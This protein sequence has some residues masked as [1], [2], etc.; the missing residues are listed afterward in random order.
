MILRSALFGVRRFD[1]FQRELGTP[2]TVLSERLKKLVEN[3]LMARQMYKADG[4][5][6]RPE[7]VLTPMGEALRPALISLTQWA[8]DWLATGETPPLGFSHAKTRKPVRAGFVDSDGH[9]V[10][11]V[12]MRMAL[13][14]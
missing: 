14:R 9:A 3:G 8:D 6:A 1:D 7:Y 11:A 12:D 2:R 4:N 13:R 5:R 10:E